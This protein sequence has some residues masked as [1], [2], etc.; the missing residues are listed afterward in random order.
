LALTLSARGDVLRA[1]VVTPP[2]E[3]ENAPVTSQARS[4]TLSDMLARGVHN[5]LWV[6]ITLVVAIGLGALHALEPGHGKTLLAV[7]LVGARATSAQAL[8]LAFALTLA[9]TAGVLALGII[10]VFAAGWIVPERIYPWI[11]LLSG[12]VVAFMAAS[13]LERTVRKNRG[14]QHDHVGLAHSHES[15][16]R[17]PHPTTG[18]HSHGHDHGHQ[19]DHALLDGQALSFRKVVLL[20]MSGNI[21][22][23]PAALVVLLAALTLHEITYGLVVIV[24][25]SLG[26]ALV[27]TALGIGLVRSAAWIATRPHFDKLT[28]HAPLASAC[29]IAVIG[30]LMLAQGA[31]ATL[32]TPPVLV[33]LLTLV[34]IASFAFAPGHTHA[35]GPSVHGSGA[36]S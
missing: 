36:P 20:A 18:N 31:G 25:F 6:V 2:E 15:S 3:P 22:P 19:H 16:T 35:H 12:A 17:Y 5:P 26:L 1:A 33:A 13:A 32:Q 29:I 4:N 8:Q 34:A 21:A 30:S 24:A 14:A 11:T 27:L 7:S 9:H 28:A 10:L 23:C